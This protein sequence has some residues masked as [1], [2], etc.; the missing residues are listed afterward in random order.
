MILNR[1]EFSNCVYK[2]GQREYLL[3][4]KSHGGK[5]TMSSPCFENRKD[6]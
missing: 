5:L 3:V 2:Q 4:I 6:H 1:A